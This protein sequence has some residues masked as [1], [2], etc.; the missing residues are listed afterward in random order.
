MSIDP[1]YKC[2]KATSILLR[3][4]YKATDDRGLASYLDSSSFKDSLYEKYVFA[5]VESITI[6]LRPCGGMAD[7]ILRSMCGQHQGRDE[8]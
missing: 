8:T 6:D 2:E 5:E 7:Y 4:L 1:N 3:E